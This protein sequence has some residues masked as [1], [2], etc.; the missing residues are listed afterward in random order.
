MSADSDW[1]EA[2]LVFFW[3]DYST[4]KR[5]C[6]RAQALKA[7]NRIPHSDPQT[8]FDHLDAA[9]GEARA[10]WVAEKREIVH[11]PHAVTW[12]NDY[13][14]NLSLDAL[15]AQSLNLTTNDGNNKA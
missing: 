5:A 11:I 9:F 14:A 8:A 10:L 13:R 3:P 15:L 6:S 2:F 4:L 12:L 1:A 7:W